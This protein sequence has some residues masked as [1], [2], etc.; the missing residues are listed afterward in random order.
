MA[1]LE[2]GGAPMRSQR[3]K[4]PMS[5]TSARRAWL[6]GRWGRAKQGRAMCVSNWGTTLWW[7]CS[8]MAKAQRRW[9]LFGV[10]TVSTRANERGRGWK[11][12]EAVVMPPSSLTFGQTSWADAGVWPP[13][14]VCGLALVGHDELGLNRFKPI[15]CRHGRL[16]ANS[17]PSSIS[18]TI[19]SL[20]KP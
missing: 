18:Q 14:G 2:L 6:A 17:F 1:S 15:Q 11:C 8:M 5:F 12:T 4:W 9:R 3:Q 16:K 20:W 13:R 10:A 7:R 19:A